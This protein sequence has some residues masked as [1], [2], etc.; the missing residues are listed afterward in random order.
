ML[1]TLQDLKRFFKNGVDRDLAKILKGY[2]TKSCCIRLFFRTNTSYKRIQCVVKCELLC[3]STNLILPRFKTK[4]CP[5][6]FFG[7]FSLKG[8]TVFLYI[9]ML[10]ALIFCN[11]TP[12]LFTCILKT[13]FYYALIQLTWGEKL[14]RN[15]NIH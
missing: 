13:R 3:I 8:Q 1:F 2:H 9:F 15:I 5:T 4:H 11:S 12:K 6:G 10:S 7:I 14:S